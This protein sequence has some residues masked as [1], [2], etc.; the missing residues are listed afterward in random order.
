MAQSVE[1]LD[2]ARM[3]AMA[4]ALHLPAVAVEAEL[5]A[6]VRSGVQLGVDRFYTVPA[7]G[8]R[9]QMVDGDGRL[10]AV[11]RGDGGRVVYERV[12][13]A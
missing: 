11:A 12:F 13:K 9:F 8:E 10:L 6:K 4:A 5:V 2:L 3:V 7:G 1:T